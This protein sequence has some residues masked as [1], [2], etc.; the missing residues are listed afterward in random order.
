MLSQASY[1]NVPAG[2]D[3]LENEEERYMASK[4]RTERTGAYS[5]AHSK[6]PSPFEVL[7][8]PRSSEVTSM[9]PHYNLK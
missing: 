7:F 4:H 1:F 3:T 6:S 5:K 8:L 9:K 2:L